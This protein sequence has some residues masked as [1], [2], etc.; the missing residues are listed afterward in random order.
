MDQRHACPHCGKS[1]KEKFNLNKHVRSVHE[2]RRYTCRECD[3]IFNR[4][5][6]LVE[7]VS[8]VHQ[9]RFHCDECYAYF[10]VHRN[11]L[12]HTRSVHQKRRFNC[13]ECDATFSRHNPLLDHVRLFHRKKK[14]VDG[15]EKRCNFCRLPKQLVPGKPYCE[16]CI[17]GCK[18]CPGCRMPRPPHYFE[19]DDARLCATCDKKTQHGGSSIRTALGGAIEEQDVPVTRPSARADLLSALE[20]C[21]S[22]LKTRL[23][24]ALK[25]KKGVKWFLKCVA[26]LSKVNA[27][28][29]VVFTE[30]SLQ[31]SPHVLLEGSYL[32]AQLAEVFREI[33]SALSNYQRH[34]SVGFS[35][36]L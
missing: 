20:D 35:C 30:A 2:K 10:R 13:P 1:F 36:K 31:S 9:R 16:S 33:F 22:D 25:E 12:E 19:D 15:H 5:D 7:H 27:S 26:E 4:N 17:R 14:V 24:Y 6:K 32:D 18:E 11:L 29:E 23:E 34:G 21:E 3:A 8:G 28:G